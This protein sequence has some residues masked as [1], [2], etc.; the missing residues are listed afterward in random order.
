MPVATRVP[1]MKSLTLPEPTRIATMLNAKAQS[2]VR[3]SEGLFSFT[4]A[5]HSEYQSLP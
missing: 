3:N 1:A 5:L 4:A 2:P